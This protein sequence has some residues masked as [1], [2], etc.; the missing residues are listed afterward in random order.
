MPVPNSLLLSH[1]QPRWIKVSPLRQGRSQNSRHRCGGS[2]RRAAS[3]LSPKG[4]GCGAGATQRLRLATPFLSTDV[5]PTEHA[6]R[7]I[8][9]K[10]AFDASSPDKEVTIRRRYGSV[11]AAVLIRHTRAEAKAVHAGGVRAGTVGLRQALD[12]LAVVHVAVR[13]QAIVAGCAL[14][15]RR[16][17]GAACVIDARGPCRGAV[18]VDVARYA[19]VVPRIADL[20]RHAVAVRKALN[21]LLR[22]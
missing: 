8:H 20:R 4:C 15:V 7:A 10:P 17:A 1:G 18:G 2:R 11:L 21:A 6:R 14:R 5:I 22:H 9:A 12:A 19:Q 3:E 16:A 13:E